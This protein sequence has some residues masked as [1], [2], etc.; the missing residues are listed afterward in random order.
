MV[1]RSA[2]P[3]GAGCLIASIAQGILSKCGVLA[4]HELEYQ[5]V[6]GGWTH[7]ALRRP[8]CSSGRARY[9]RLTRVAR[10]ASE[11]AHHPSPPYGVPASSRRTSHLVLARRKYNRV[12]L[13]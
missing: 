2:E 4:D 13:M 11:L 8:S 1:R 3:G 9:A 5:R 6:A 12:L 7:R 10:R